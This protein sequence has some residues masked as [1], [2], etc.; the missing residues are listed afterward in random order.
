MPRLGE[1]EKK[2]SQFIEMPSLPWLNQALNG[3]FVRGGAYLLTGSAGAG[4]TT[5]AVQI[6]GDLAK[7]GDKV[8]YFATE[9]PISEF[10]AAVERIHSK[11]GALPPG[12][13]Q[14]L[15]VDDAI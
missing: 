2:G 15:L 13:V 14:N 4:K 3:G 5:L 8:L 11:G 6:V 12:I 1:I 10:K 9:Q 7:R